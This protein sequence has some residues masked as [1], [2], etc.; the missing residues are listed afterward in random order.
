MKGKP[1][2]Q[3]PENQLLEI[4]RP[5]YGLADSEDY[6]HDMFLGNIKGDLK[7]QS[8]ACDLSLFFKHVQ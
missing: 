8:K 3:L 2:L 5:L 4:L 6:W 7:M 1:E